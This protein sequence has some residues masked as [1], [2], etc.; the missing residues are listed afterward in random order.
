MIDQIS[1]LI[2]FVRQFWGHCGDGT[3]ENVQ[4]CNALSYNHMAS[5]GQPS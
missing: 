1:N 5:I 3:S 4:A 2:T